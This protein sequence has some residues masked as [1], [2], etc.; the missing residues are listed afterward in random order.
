MRRG[1][2]CCLALVLALAGSA[3]AGTGGWQQ[4]HVQVLTI[5]YRTHDGDR[6]AAYVV[7]PDWYGPRDNPR[8][9]LVISPHGRGV[10]GDGN[11][12]L[13]GNLPALGDFAVV[14]PD[15][16]GRRLSGR[17][18]WGAPGDIDD[19]AR[20]P[21]LVERVLGIRIDPHHV[22]AVGGSMG[23]QETLLLIARHPKLLAG[24]VA[25]DAA[26]DFGRQ[27]R[28]FAELH[29]LKP[30]CNRAWGGDLGQTLQR[31]A[32]Q[33]V[34]GTPQTAR[35]A[36]AARSPLTYAAQIAASGVPLQIWWS[37]TDRVIRQ[38]RL[39]SGRLATELRR[40][41]PRAPLT[42]VSGSWRH[43]HVLRYD[44]ELPQMLARLGLLT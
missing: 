7:L 30:S 3:S 28:N 25:V 44:R 26:T 36:F 32:R 6:R 42:V 21:R 2:L 37:R 33:E 24:A 15:G 35:A 1:G 40:L 10:D 38:S 22:Y 17:F 14:N 20:M 43:T 16:S 19:L 13:W 11:A 27:Y 23:A 9:P 4:V 39:Q 8:L 41:H 5:P 31:L 29:C 12:R 34:G 18:A